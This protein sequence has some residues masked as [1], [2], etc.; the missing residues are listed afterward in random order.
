MT[1]EKTVNYIISK[2][3]IIKNKSKILDP[4]VG[5]GIFVKILVK[6]G[7]NP[8]KIYAFDIDNSYKTDLQALGINFTQ[9]D[10]LLDIRERDH[11]KFDY[12]IG[13]PP[14]LNKSSN[15]IKKNKQSLK[16]IYGHINA[17][18]SYAMFIVNNIW[19]LK[20]GG[21][22]AFITSDSFLT[23]RTHTRLREYILKTCQIKEILLA[24]Q[25]LFEDQGVNTF[26]SI[27]VLKKFTG[28]SNRE[29]RRDNLVRIIPRIENED[30]YERPPKVKTITQLL[31]EPN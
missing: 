2:L 31:K 19:R 25:N 23:L 7:V 6:K 28:D 24:P 10:T 1:P 13:N 30:Y 12:I 17:H 26:T 22:L 29:R 11:N 15:Y 20:E 8:E 4:C 9:K 16:K 18:E 14:Y 3:G 21:F 27:L 5:P